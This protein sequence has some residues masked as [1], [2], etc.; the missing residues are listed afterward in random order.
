MIHRVGGPREK[1]NSSMGAAFRHKMHE[2][3]RQCL[4]SIVPL[5]LL[6]T[7]LLLGACGGGG[8]G[9]TPS[10]NTGTVTPPT[11]PPPTSGLVSTASGFSPTCAG[12]PNSGILYANSEVEPHIAI[13][14][15]NP[16]NLI[17]TWQQDRWSNGGAQGIAVAASFDAGATWTNRSLPVSRCGE[18]TAANGGDYD[19][20]EAL[21]TPRLLALWTDMEKDSGGEV[22]RIDFFYWTS[23][24]D[25][26]LKDVSIGSA[27]VD[28]HE[29]RQMV[30]ASFRNGGE[31]RRI[32]FYFER[33]GGKWRLDDV[34]S[35]VG[36][37]W[38]LSVLLKYGWPGGN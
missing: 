2:G 9:G 30:T 38:T 8:G 7:A 36:E 24:Q 37:I 4:T 26:D 12:V 16:N 10:P 15:T 13:N 17:S 23:S 29:D 19:P 1:S 6:A 22:G 21:Y 27:F 34:V 18:G 11:I 35:E 25:W 33:T 20:P 31:P 5:Y 3:A 28:G 32:R 14:P